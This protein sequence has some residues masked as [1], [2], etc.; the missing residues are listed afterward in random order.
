MRLS[1]AEVAQA[2][3][4][5]VTGPAGAVVDSYHT[6]SREVAPGGLFFALSGSETDG[7]RFLAD[8][9][10]RG[11]AAVVVDRE[12]DAGG[13]PVVRVTDTWAALYDLARHVLARVSP[14]VVGVTGSNGKTSTKEFAA[15]A[16]SPRF[17]TWKTHGNLNTETGVPLTILHLEPEH[18]ALV[19][20]MGMQ[21]PGEIA[22][23]AA[24]AQPWVGIITTVG[25]VHLEFFDSQEDLARAKGELVAALPA[26]GLAVLPAGSEHL[27][28]L[29]A[30]S[31]APVTT[32]GPG[33]DWDYDG[34]RPEGAGSRFQVRGVEV[35]LRLGGRH[36]AANAL[37][38]L[39][40]ADFAGVPL[41]AAAAALAEVTV[42]QRLAELEAPGGFTVVDD[43]YNASPESMLAAFATVAERPHRGRLLAVLGEMRELGQVA[44]Q[45]HVE[46]GRR[47][48]EV[49]DA[50][51]VIDVGRGALLAE[52]AGGQLA[53]DREAA[54]AWVRAQ[55]RPGD[56]VL[57]KA[58][59]GV[60]LEELVA[61]LLDGAA[62]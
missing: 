31:T 30:L 59:H 36:M 44:D 16:L 12:V 53:P 27:E 57:V 56:T 62:S 7:H 38:A 17:R 23:L 3:G 50:V 26:D 54:L 13:A 10:E 15:A 6:D 24:L 60:H 25:T 47:A 2:T 14:L 20:E 52:A 37:A 34:Y 46:V 19:L 4:G 28:V 9:I 22:R 49:F 29:R 61:R 18:Q 32:F 42:L 43:S 11:A 55:A 1:L 35:A 33:G 48:R 5:A 21:A 39:A 8:A 45:A 58:S 51:C 41:P 40:A